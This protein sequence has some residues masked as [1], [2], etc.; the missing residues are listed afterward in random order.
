MQLVVQLENKYNFLDKSG[1]KNRICY[2][3]YVI[4]VKENMVSLVLSK[5]VIFAD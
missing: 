5:I 2:L 3:T 1:I 4:K